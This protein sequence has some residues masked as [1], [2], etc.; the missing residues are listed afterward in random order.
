MHVT[1]DERLKNFITVYFVLSFCSS[2]LIKTE[3]ENWYNVSNHVI[4]VPPFDF[5]TFSFR[6]WISVSIFGRDLKMIF[7]V[8][9]LIRRFHKL[10]DK[11]IG[12][13][14]GA[15]FNLGHRTVMHRLHNTR[16]FQLMCFF[17]CFFFLPTLF[18][19]FGLRQTL[20]Q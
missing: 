17:F 20:I 2:V 6:N 7:L 1:I 3:T 14:I 9:S 12:K 10:T 13:R 11:K 8:V 5:F 19:F 4:E 16:Y 15:L 18:C